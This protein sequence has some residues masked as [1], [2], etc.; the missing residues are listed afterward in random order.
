MLG[1]QVKLFNKVL[2]IPLVYTSI[3]QHLLAKPS[4]KA[5]TMEKLEDNSTQIPPVLESEGDD[6]R[7]QESLYENRN[8]CPEGDEETNLKARIE[9]AEK[10][11][12]KTSRDKLELIKNISRRKVC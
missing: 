12:V 5:N 8:Q 2:C 3:Y 6:I 11:V 7:L 1:V 9:E 10:V 4:R